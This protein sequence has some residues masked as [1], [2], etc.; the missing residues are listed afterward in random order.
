MFE[1]L[2]VTVKRNND[3]IEKMIF[4]SAMMRIS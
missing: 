2:A 3:L 4:H 1:R